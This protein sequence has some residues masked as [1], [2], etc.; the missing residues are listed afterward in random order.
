IGLNDIDHTSSAYIGVD[1]QP[2]DGCES[3]ATSIANL[4]S[5]PGFG[6][7][8]PTVLLTKGAKKAAV[9][10]FLSDQATN[11]LQD[12]DL[13]VLH[14]SGHGMQGSL[15]DSGQPDIGSTVTTC[16]VLYDEPLSNHELA[17]ILLQFKPGVRILVL[18]D[19]CF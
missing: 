2:L 12:G 3:D 19:S 13:L 15:D 4:V 18:S 10:G 5:Q 6:F 9:T 14:Y 17:Q 16:W 8:P 1:A 7:D 11:V